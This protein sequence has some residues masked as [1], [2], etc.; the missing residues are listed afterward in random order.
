MEC[1]TQVVDISQPDLPIS[2][3]NCP[4]AAPER[5]SLFPRS[6]NSL[7]LFVSS[8]QRQVMAEEK[9]QHKEEAVAPSPSHLE[10]LDTFKQVERRLVRKI[11]MR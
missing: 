6:D 10:D 3:L 8:S 7:L 2:A 1:Y 5:I 9:V 11:D 4:S